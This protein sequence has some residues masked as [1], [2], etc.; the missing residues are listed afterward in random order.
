VTVIAVRVLVVVITQRYR[1]SNSC[2]CIGSCDDTEIPCSYNDT[3]TV[4]AVRV[5]VVVI[6]QRYRVVPMSDTVTV[7]AV[8]V[9]VVVM[10]QRY[11]VVTMTL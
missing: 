9:S 4:I 2:T 3:V 10:T 8:R 11:R 5:L 7:I 6:T 1:V